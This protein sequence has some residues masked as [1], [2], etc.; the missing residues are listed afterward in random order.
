MSREICG[1][2]RFSVEIWLDFSR[3]TA[4]FEGVLPA[5]AGGAPAGSGIRA[6]SRRNGRM[7]ASA[8]RDAMADMS[9]QAAQLR[10]WLRRELPGKI[11]RLIYLLV[12][13]CSSF[14]PAGG[15]LS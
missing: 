10:T 15:P 13:A 9:L 2:C 7:F 14:V 11:D 4:P 5:G 3:V 8:A 6:A 1:C 12:D